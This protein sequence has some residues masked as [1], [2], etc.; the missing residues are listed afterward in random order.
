MIETLFNYGIL[1]GV[2]IFFVIIVSL[3]SRS[4]ILSSLFKFLGKLLL[5]LLQIAMIAVFTVIISL[6][7]GLIIFIHPLVLG[8]PQFFANGE[9]VHLLAAEPDGYG[10][11]Q[12]AFTYGFMYI[13]LYFIALRFLAKTGVTKFFYS[14][15]RKIRMIFPY[16]RSHKYLETKLVGTACQLLTTSCLILLYPLV[17]ATLFPHLELTMT[18]NVAIFICL[19]IFSM[20]PLPGYAD[21]RE[22]KQRPY[23][24]TG[25]MRNR[26]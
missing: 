17:I 3:V 4:R 7:V 25:T 14:I 22:E 21:T 26:I 5:V 16:R 23:L 19:F 6:L 1:F 11:M 20:V 24:R 9:A 2:V 18:G 10:L 13:I 12:F 15:A 8:E